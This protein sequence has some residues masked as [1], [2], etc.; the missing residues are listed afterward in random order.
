MIDKE[1]AGSKLKVPL[2]ATKLPRPARIAKAPVV[3]AVLNEIKGEGIEQ[4][5]NYMVAF[6]SCVAVAMGDRDC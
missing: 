6:K 4:L 3:K 1:N 5:T 2:V